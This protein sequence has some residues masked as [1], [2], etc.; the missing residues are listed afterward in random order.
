MCLYPIRK[1]AIFFLVYSKKERTNNE[2]KNRHCRYISHADDL[3]RNYN[4]SYKYKL[5]NFL[6]HWEMVYLMTKYF[7]KYVKRYL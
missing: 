2:I 7:F 6:L 4:I 1:F 5:L 3:T